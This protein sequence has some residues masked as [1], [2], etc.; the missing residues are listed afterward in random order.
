MCVCHLCGCRGWVYV[1]VC[2]RLCGCRVWVYGCVCVCVCVVVGGGCTC[3]CRLCGC[4][5]LCGCRGMGVRLCPDSIF[6]RVKR[7]SN[8]WDRKL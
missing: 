8:K 4:V 1:C 3:V 6:S 2:V 7:L 5:R